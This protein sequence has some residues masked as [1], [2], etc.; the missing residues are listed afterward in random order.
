MPLVA[1][2]PNLS[3][4]QSP[5]C[6]FRSGISLDQAFGL[7]FL[8]ATPSGLFIRADTWV[9]PYDDAVTM[10]GHVTHGPTYLR[11]AG[12]ADFRRGVCR[13][14]AKDNTAFARIISPAMPIDVVPKKGS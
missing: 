11:L 14:H 1:N 4:G 12:R 3:I 8:Y 7:K 9:C 13:L 2:N 5:C 6:V 10:V